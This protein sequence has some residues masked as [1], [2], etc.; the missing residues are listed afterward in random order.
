VVTASADG[1]AR[2]WSFANDVRPTED[3]ISLAHLLSGSWIDKSGDLA[4]IGMDEF[5]NA[6]R[7]LREKY[8]DDFV[9]S[10]QEILAWYWREAADCE[11]SGDWAS[12]IQ[13]LDSLVKAKPED[14]MLLKLR[15]QAYAE[16]GQWDKA[17][18][19][20]A[21]ATELDAGNRSSWTSLAKA[22]L[23]AGD[24]DGYRQACTSL[25]GRFGQTNNPT[26]ASD[27]AWTCTLAPD[28]VADWKAVVRLA[29]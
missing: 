8:P 28:A 9:C 26:D 1:T 4:P 14:W 11:A 15:G 10:P 27:I 7:T 18:A 21:K 24:V 16:L 22:K 12:A 5:R 25:L 29:E 2:V 23:A 20:F 13:H 6:W 19:D 17:I 3:V